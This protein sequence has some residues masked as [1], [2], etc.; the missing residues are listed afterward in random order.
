MLALQIA[1]GKELFS[2][3]I[4]RKAFQGALGTGAK[5]QKG[6]ESAR[7]R[8]GGQKSTEVVRQGDNGTAR[9][10]QMVEKCEWERQAGEAVSL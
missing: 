2:F 3:Y 4:F 7:K 10:S 9:H 1:K 6:S 5:G 8:S